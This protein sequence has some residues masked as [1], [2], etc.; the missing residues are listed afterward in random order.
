MMGNAALD[1]K[2]LPFVPFVPFVLFVLS[3]SSRVLFLIPALRVGLFAEGRAVGGAIRRGCRGT[4][5]E[6]RA[7][8]KTKKD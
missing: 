2:K 6:R 4:V 5:I 3:F 7:R 1:K 8:Y